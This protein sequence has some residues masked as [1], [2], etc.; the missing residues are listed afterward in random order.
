[1]NLCM[2][3][4]QNRWPTKSSEVQKLLGPGPVN[5]IL[6]LSEMLVSHRR[7]NRG[8]GADVDWRAGEQETHTDETSIQS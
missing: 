3:D 1:M 8:W 4:L 7:G 6:G 5:V 2:G